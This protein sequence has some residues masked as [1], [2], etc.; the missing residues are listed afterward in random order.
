MGVSGDADTWRVWLCFTINGLVFGAGRVSF[1]LQLSRFRHFHPF[2]MNALIR[3]SPLTALDRMVAGFASWFSALRRPFPRLGALALTFL[4]CAGMVHA[5]VPTD[6][7][8]SSVTINQSAAT[9]GVTVATLTTL[10]ADVGDTHTYSLVAGPGSTNNGSFAIVGANLNVGPVALA[11][12]SYTIRIRTTD[13][14][15]NNYDEIVIITVNDNVQPVITGTVA[16]SNASYAAGA[17]LTFTAYFSEVVNVNT[18]LGTPRIA[19][20]LNTGGTVYATYL[21]GS[22]SLAIS[23]R[24][25]VQPGDLDLDGISVAGSI[26]LNGGTIRDAAAN[27]AVLTLNGVGSTAGIVIDGVQLTVMSV[28]APGS[29]TYRSG[30]SMDFV[31]TF[32]KTTFVDLTG[33]APRIQVFLESGTTAYAVYNSGHASNQFVFR[34]TVAVGDFD[35]NGINL[36]GAVLLNGSVIRDGA[37]NP[38]A[39]ALNNIAPLT[40][41]KVDGLPPTITSITRNNASPTSATT[42]SYTI[43]FAEPVSGADIT[44]FELTTTGTA[45]GTLSTLNQTDTVTYVATVSSVTGDGTL[46]LDLKASNTSI[47]DAV[48]NPIS[49][50][51]TLGQ[52]YTIDNTRPAVTIGSPSVTSTE[53]GPVAYTLTYAGAETVSLTPEQV[54]LN[55]TGSVAATVQITGSGNANRTVTLTNITGAGTIGISVAAGSATDLAGN[56]SLA[57]G[58]SETVPVNPAPALVI[59]IPNQSVGYKTPFIYTIPSGTF[60]EPN[61]EQT[62]T[63]SATGMPAGITFD[64]GTRSFSGIA[65]IGTAQITVT[66]T[67]NG[68]PIRSTSSVFTL[69]IIKAV[70]T[71]RADNKTRAYGAA[72]PPLTVTYSGFVGGETLETSGVTGLPVVT[73]TAVGTTPVGTVPITATVGTLDATN[74]SFNLVPG[75]L[76][77]SKAV[78]TVKAEDKTR[79]YNTINP[80][81]TYTLTGLVNGETLATVSGAPELST[82]VTAVT[83]VGTYPILITIGTLASTNYSFTGL[84]NGVFTVTPAPVT[85]TL[86]DLFKVYNGQPQTVT[87]TT[88]PSGNRVKFT[89][90]GNTATPTEAG[91]YTV[92]ATSDDA[93][94]AGTATATLSIAKAPQT[95][96]FN[97]PTAAVGTPITLTATSSSGLPVTFTVISGNATLAGTTLTLLDT[98]SVTVRAIQAGNANYSTTS[99]DR[100]ISATSRLS[101]TITVTPPGDKRT[102]APPFALQATS[103]SGLPVTIALQSGPALLSGNV[104]T[105][106]GSVG[107]VSFRLSQAGND[108]FSPAPDVTVTFNVILAR[109]DRIINLSSRS[110]VA[111]DGGVLI[112]GFVVGG[113]AAKQ[114]LIRGIGPS[115]APFGVQGVMPNPTV[116][117]YRGTSLI[118]ENTGWSL[119]GNGAVLSAAFA[120]LGAFALPNN[121]LDSAMLVTLQPGAYSVHV[122]GSAGVALAEIYDASAN[123]QAE[124][125]RLVNIS[126][127]ND[128][129][130]GDNALIGGFVISGTTS[131]KVLIR[132]VGPALVPFGVTNALADSRVQVFSGT[133]Q[134][135][136]NDNWSAVPAEAAAVSEAAL[137]VGAFA[138]PA[139]SKDAALVMTLAPGGYTLQVS[140][141]VAGA[142]GVALI[143]VYELP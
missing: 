62:L 116:R 125:Q 15:L 6:I 141:A 131:K 79:V 120:R 34:Y 58:P 108:T 5:A 104:V 96:T 39:T 48:G 77:I 7:G 49:S 12:G 133:T 38:L 71:V 65:P 63:Y 94:F 23:F 25:I 121:S 78:L 136:E 1:S 17:Q 114:V 52:I 110:R 119:G 67:D 31:V 87:V 21:A 134:I 22:G 75:T 129:G 11:A 3:L 40:A 66:A 45:T 128:A 20:T 42:V 100:T 57:A 86:S 47:I 113:T 29:G 99:L 115:L 9:V 46:R 68:F 142:T 111:T 64:P 27:N 8:L 88:V 24:Y 97:P 82:D 54:T 80:P 19:L 126:V 124:E 44:D 16:P 60:V 112:T 28:S 139:G 137:T 102:D 103:T 43:T 143:E 89:Y 37:S 32:S 90:N 70:L 83:N 14:A 106:T 72:N 105:L 30:V 95:L 135:G 18:T 92:V 84:T 76:T 93:N 81:L 50:G 85:I 61:P 51:F 74:Y 101:Q 56:L 117:L 118:S 41:V 35:S 73:T 130:T 59:P 2:F 10:D 36:G 53:T 138:L 33:G 91:S 140:S 69:S 127:R 132:G 98:G 123:P 4:S 107:T 55:V 109:N 26:D 122:T 13:V